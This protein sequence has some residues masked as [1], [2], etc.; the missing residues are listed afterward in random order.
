MQ[1]LKIGL[2]KEGKLP[3]DKRVPLSPEQS[4]LLEKKFPNVKV[5]CQSSDIRCFSD[6][7]YKNHGIEVVGHW[8]TVTYC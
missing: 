1:K 7:E 5:Y 8:I 2:L 6:E 4:A 3:I